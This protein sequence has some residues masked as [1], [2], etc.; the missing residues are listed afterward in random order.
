M[1]S[2]IDRPLL[3]RRAGCQT[4]NRLRMD[5]A[6]DSVAAPVL[7]S[8]QTAARDHERRCVYS[9]LRPKMRRRSFWAPARSAL[10]MFQ[11]I[12]PAV[13]FCAARGGRCRP[14]SRV[15]AGHQRRD[16]VSRSW[17]SVSG[18]RRP[19]SMGPPLTESPGRCQ[20]FERTR[21]GSRN[22]PTQPCVAGAACSERVTKSGGQASGAG[23]INCGALRLS[24]GKPASSLTPH[25]ANCTAR[26][27]PRARPRG[28]AKA[29]SGSATAGAG[30]D[31]D[32]FS[33][34]R[35][36]RAR[37]LRAGSVDTRRRWP[38]SAFRR[39]RVASESALDARLSSG[40]DAKHGGMRA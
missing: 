39:L 1:S 25:K 32:A 30:N 6:V 4:W 5:R 12:R 10:K 2:V 36:N 8:M 28:R 34:L 40:P 23:Q 13:H 19:T 21:M 3:D 20:V 17:G 22:W 7:W 26:G 29:D 24:R 27:L 11:W 14:T 16:R 31:C 18:C 37:S 38:S 33:F 35:R 15:G 9:K